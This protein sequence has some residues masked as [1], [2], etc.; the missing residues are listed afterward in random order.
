L[1]EC[2]SVEQVAGDVVEPYTLAQVIE[3]LSFALQFFVRVKAVA[4]ANRCSAGLWLVVLTMST[5]NLRPFGG[6][7]KNKREIPYSSRHPKHGE[8]RFLGPN[9]IK[10]SQKLLQTVAR[11]ISSSAR[12]AAADGMRKSGTP[13]WNVHAVS[14]LLAYFATGA[15]A[16]VTDTVPRLLGRPATSFEQFVKDHREVA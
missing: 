9:S 8:C 2:T 3:W 16:T 5:N 13:D 14:E 6:W 11:P 12:E 10:K 4:R 15:V 1:F 7:R